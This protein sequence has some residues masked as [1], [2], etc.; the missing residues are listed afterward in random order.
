MSQ[1]VICAICNRSLYVHTNED[2]V[3]YLHSLIE[4]EPH[5]VVPIMAPPGWAGGECD[6]CSAKP[7]R[8]ELP[9]RDFRGPLLDQLMS[10]GAWSACEA[11][12]RLIE[13]NRWN[14][15][16][17][18]AATTFEHRHGYPLNPADQA[19]LRALYRRLRKHISGSLRP[20]S[21]EEG[22]N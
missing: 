18:H 19:H 2:G 7:P 20:I 5:P 6:F 13:A 10:A 8:F 1:P 14:E 3:T 15:L 22:T 12:A 11:C 17:R 16:E 9:V 4:P 21:P